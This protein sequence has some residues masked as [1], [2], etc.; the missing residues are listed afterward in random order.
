MRI[1]VQSQ[2]RQI[3]LQRPY[4]DKTLHKKRAGG[5][6]QGVGPEFKPQYHQKKKKNERNI[7]CTIFQ[8][9]CLIIMRTTRVCVCVCVCVCAL[10]HGCVF[11]SVFLV[12]DCTA[13]PSEITD[14]TRELD[15]ILPKSIFSFYFSNFGNDKITLIRNKIYE[16]TV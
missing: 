4:L 9:P 3:V 11:L 5:V 12:K 1:E 8:I 15:V 6:A 14:I 2:P 7:F 10:T 13:S 16:N